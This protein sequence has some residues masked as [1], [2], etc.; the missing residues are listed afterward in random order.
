M[1]DGL[2]SIRLDRLN[3]P[4]ET[5]RRQSHPATDRRLKQ[6]LEEHGVLVPLIV[7]RLGR[8]EF[9]VWDGTRRVRLLRELGLPGSA[10]VPAVLGRGQDAESVVVQINV[11]QTR[12]RLSALAEAEALRQLVKDHG[13]TQEQ[14]GAAILKTKS[15]V[16]K[17]LKIWKLPKRVLADVSAGRIAFAHAM[18]LTRYLNQPKILAALHKEALK[19]ATATLQLSAMGRRMEKEGPGAARRYAPKKYPIGAKSWV[20]IEPL[21]RGFRAEVHVNDGDDAQAA[22]AALVKV[23]GKL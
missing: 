11:N 10:L 5:L 1:S 21:Q 20:R 2:L 18:V 23:L 6:S 16:S 22:I 7:S 15:W 14:A 12:E 4:V 8:G 17:V 19:G 9:A 13:W 3:V